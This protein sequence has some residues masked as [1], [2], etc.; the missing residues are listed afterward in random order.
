MY[1]SNLELVKFKINFDDKEQAKI[2]VFTY[3]TILDNNIR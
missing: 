2:I 3:F 1:V